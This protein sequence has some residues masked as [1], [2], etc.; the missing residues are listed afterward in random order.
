VG[1][2]KTAKTEGR[3]REREGRIGAYLKGGSEKVFLVYHSAY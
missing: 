3:E 1:I 2:D